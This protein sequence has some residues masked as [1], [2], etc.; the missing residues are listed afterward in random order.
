MCL[1]KGGDSF[2]LPV[3]IGW[4]SCSGVKHI[5]EVAVSDQ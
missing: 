1:P 4:S 2:S 3:A 5:D